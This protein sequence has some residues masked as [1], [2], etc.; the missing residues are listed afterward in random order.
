MIG[1]LAKQ[2][3]LIKISLSVVFSDEQKLIKGIKYTR[4]N[5][6]EPLF[7]VHRLEEEGRYVMEW[8]FVLSKECLDRFVQSEMRHLEDSRLYKK[9]IE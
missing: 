8:V 2:M 7:L 4:L 9:A 3:S 5:E 1:L 6:D